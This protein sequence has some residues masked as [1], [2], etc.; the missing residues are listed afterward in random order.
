MEPSQNYKMLHGR[1]VGVDMGTNPSTRFLIL[2]MLG[3]RIRLQI[4]LEV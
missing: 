1:T 2:K 3:S 4:F